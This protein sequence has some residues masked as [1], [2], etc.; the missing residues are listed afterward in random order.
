MV[1]FCCSSYISDLRGLFDKGTR[2]F[3]RFWFDM[4]EQV[5]EAFSPGKLSQLVRIH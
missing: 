1:K 2:E 5:C 4:M 3:G